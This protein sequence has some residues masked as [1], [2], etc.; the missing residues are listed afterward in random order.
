[1]GKIQTEAQGSSG[2]IL[3]LWDKII[4]NVEMVADGNRCITGKFTSLNDNW[5]WHLTGVYADCNR[6]TRRMARVDQ[7]EKYMSWAMDSMW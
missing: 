5:S 1:M 3:I 2:R 6:V 7:R 4:W